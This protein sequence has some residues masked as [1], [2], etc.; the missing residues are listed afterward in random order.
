MTIDYVARWFG[1]SRQTLQRLVRTN[2]KTLMAKITDLKKNR[3]CD[4]LS[5]GNKSITEIASSLGFGSSVSFTRAFKSWANLSPKRYREL[6]R[7]K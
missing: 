2:G 3:A 4:E 7:S 6:H 1:V 5:N